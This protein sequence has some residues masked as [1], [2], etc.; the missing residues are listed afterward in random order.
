MIK[1]IFTPL[2]FLI[3]IY[4]LTSCSTYSNKYYPVRNH[5]PRV[6]TLGFHVS[7]PPGMDW[8]EKHVDASLYY[9]KKT[10][11][12]TYALT[13]RATELTF[14]DSFTLKD[15]FLEYV[16]TQKS[17]HKGPKDRY[18][19]CTI[20]YYIEESLSRL[21]IRY[22][23]NYDDYGDEGRGDYEFVKVI[24]KGLVCQHPE[25]PRIGIDINYLEKSIPQVNNPSYRNE[26]ENFLS[27]LSFFSSSKY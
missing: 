3:L 17:I 19:N 9:L 24:N 1:N 23:L 6:S 4:L 16:K 27:S 10:K 11:P 22:Q 2:S 20:E 8:Y 21:C 7:P 18:R 25:S 14:K 5:N 13:T 15:D 26:G 12:Y